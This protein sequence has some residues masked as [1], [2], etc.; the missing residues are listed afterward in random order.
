[1]VVCEL[2]IAEFYCLY[3]MLLRSEVIF[4]CSTIVYETKKT[5]RRSERREVRYLERVKTLINVVLLRLITVMSVFN[6]FIA[7]E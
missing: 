6:A 4:G 1:M 7:I 2:T 5:F 3:A